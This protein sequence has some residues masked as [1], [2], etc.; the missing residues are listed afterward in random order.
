MTISLKTLILLGML[1]MAHQDRPPWFGLTAAGELR[2]DTLD[3]GQGIISGS[4][5]LRRQEECQLPAYVL[6]GPK[7]LQMEVE[8]IGHC[9]EHQGNP[10]IEVVGYN[11]RALPLSKLQ[12]RWAILEEGI[13]S[14]LDFSEADR[15]EAVALALVLASYHLNSPAHAKE[16]HEAL[17][18][19]RYLYH[20]AR[21]WP[22]SL[23]NQWLVLE[24]V[25]LDFCYEARISGQGQE[26]LITNNN[27]L[28]LLSEKRPGML[29]S[30]SSAFWLL[31]NAYKRYEWALTNRKP[32]DALAYYREMN[33][34]HQSL[35]T[36]VWNQGTEDRAKSKNAGL[37][38]SDYWMLIAALGVLSIFF[39]G[40]Y[41]RRSRL[42]PLPVH[43]H[44]GYGESANPVLP[45]QEPP[46]V[47]YSF[48]N[49]P[50]VGTQPDW[51]GLWA[52]KLHTNQQWEDFKTE[53][54]RCNPG[55]LPNLRLKY[56]QLTQSDIRIACLLRMGMTSNE[57]S[58]IQNISGQGVA[59][60][61]Y[62][63]RKRMNLGPGDSISDKLKELDLGRGPA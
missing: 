56:P 53:Y 23:N 45:Y 7:P 21:Q 2:L 63:L 14:E 52:H 15:T 26:N 13:A 61:R 9:P 40:W 3:R 16:G 19:I 42:N 4:H 5:A 38:A 43:A 34:H 48:L 18:Y 8:W 46:G 10:E 51:S 33:F 55:F 39:W 62:R 30:E 36:S 54:N 32:I 60:A 37:T 31:A 22:R 41:S 35:L 28:D 6:D 58:K 44:F 11:G 59:M 49:E 24:W 47:G 17:P 29:G 20:A 25:I 12:S 27:G 50:I 57:I 1:L